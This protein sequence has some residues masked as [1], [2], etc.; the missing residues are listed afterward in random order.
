MT[1]E[2]L[3]SVLAEKVMGWTAEPNRFIKNG[4]SW[5][6]RWRFAP[7]TNLVDAIRLLDAAEPQKYTMRGGSGGAF[8][9]HVQ[10]GAETGEAEGQSRA[11]VITCAIARALGI[12]V[13]GVEVDEF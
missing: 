4:R 6:P 11:C 12:E 2:Y 3:T 10:I 8:L 1:G 9:V 5:M 13:E 7:L